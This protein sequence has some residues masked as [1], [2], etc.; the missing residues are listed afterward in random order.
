MEIMWE[1]IAA[2]SVL[3]GIVLVLRQLFRDKVSSRLLYALWLVAAL[4]LVVPF[5]IGQSPVSVAEILYEVQNMQPQMA[6]LQMDGT[7]TGGGNGSSVPEQNTAD[8]S[9]SSGYSETSGK[10]T[11]TAGKKSALQENDT[12]TVDDTVAESTSPNLKAAQEQAGQKQA[13]QKQAEQ[14]ANMQPQG[15]ALQDGWNRELFFLIWL[16]GALVILAVVAA[17][18]IRLWH[19]LRKDRKAIGKTPSAGL[20]VYETNLLATPCL[21]G[22][23]RPAV[24]MP[25]DLNAQI[26]DEERKWILCHE[27]THYRHLDGIWSALR[28]IL[29]AVY[30]FH[31]LVWVAAGCSK[32]DAELACDEAVLKNCEMK[33]KIAYGEMLLAVAGKNR[34]IPV[35]YPSTAVV[36]KKKELKKRMKVIVESNHYKKRLALLLAVCMLCGSAFTFTGCGK[37]TKTADLI[38]TDDSGAASS[39]SGIDAKPTGMSA[40]DGASG[41]QLTKEERQAAEKIFQDFLTKNQKKY[42]YYAIVLMGDD[43]TP[44]LLA[45]KN[46]IN[47]ELN[48]E[49]K[50]KKAALTVSADL[51][52]I[53]DGSTEKAAK[54]NGVAPDVSVPLSSSAKMEKTARLSNSSSGEWLHYKDG[55]LYTSEHHAM[56][57][58]RYCPEENSELIEITN[59]KEKI[60]KVSS[61]DAEYEKQYFWDFDVSDSVIFRENSGDVQI[62]LTNT[63]QYLAQILTGGEM[64]T[65]EYGIVRGDKDAKYHYDLHICD[66]NARK[67]SGKNALYVTD[68]KDRKIWTSDTSIWD[69]NSWTQ[70]YVTGNKNKA[71]LIQ[72]SP[73]YSGQK[74]TG[75]SFRQFYITPDG[76]EKVTA[77]DSVM[78]DT[79]DP[80]AGDKQNFEKFMD[81][82]WNGRLENAEFLMGTCEYLQTSLQGREMFHDELLNVRDKLQ[83]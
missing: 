21:Y 42:P 64:I 60:T 82:L 4:R 78:F 38:T 9:D 29:T 74:V 58:Y 81:N 79:A 31:P 8:T 67:K 15:A 62:D 1:M 28:V 33:E 72:V 3:I 5:S 14:G 53:I 63:N 37:D 52:C 39:G 70:Y 50:S 7:G 40:S 44:V 19:R 26:T 11:Y 55:C 71:E 43:N 20:T 65:S 83:G 48:A 18:N 32:R 49:L 24:Y 66:E 23:F 6:E 13:E 12:I 47:Q 2:S 41:V 68:I 57:R 73:S 69:P 35:L 46:K 80:K 27:E 16:A 36:S 45:S 22:V 56:S 76:K 30:W 61:Y 75:Y 10:K 77:E 25:G 59:I 51:Y 17:A 54:A 34:K